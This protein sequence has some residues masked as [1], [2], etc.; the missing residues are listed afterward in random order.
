MRFVFI[1]IF[2]TGFVLAEDP[3]SP[4]AD[5]T[6]SF[7]GISVDASPETEPRSNWV[8]RGVVVRVSEEVWAL[9]DVDL[10]RLA[11]VWRGGFPEGITIAQFSYQNTKKKAAGGQKGVPRFE[12]SVVAA[13]GMHPGLWVGSPTH[14]FE[15]LRDRGSDEKE[16][17]RGPADFVKFGKWHGVH[18]TGGRPVIE[19]VLGETVVRESWRM[20][21]GKIARDFEFERAPK[22]LCVS[23]AVDKAA[24]QG[25]GASMY[26]GARRLWLAQGF[27]TARLRLGAE[28]N[29][30]LQLQSAAVS[31]TLTVYYGSSVATD[32]GE[33]LRGEIPAASTSK[34]AG[35]A[36]WPDVIT[37]GVRLSGEAAAYVTDRLELPVNNPWRRPVRPSGIAFYED[38]RA[39]VTTVDGDVWIVSGM[40]G[41]VKALKWKRFAAGLHEPYS[42]VV[43]EREVFV[44]TRSGLQRLLDRDNDDEADFYE[45]YCH[46]FWQSAETRDFP[47]DMV[48]RS[49]GGFYLVKGGQQN[50]H[51]SKHSGRVLSV[52][53]D[54]NKVEVFSSGHRNA[55]L[56]LDSESGDLFACDQQGH[57]VPTTPVQRLRRGGYYGFRP[58]SPGGNGLPGVE[59]PVTWIPHRAGQS[60]VDVVVTRK[61]RLGRLSDSVVCVDYFRPGLLKIYENGAAVR[62]GIPFEMPLLKGAVHPKDGLLYLVG[63]QIWGT[64]AAD[65]AGL[66]RVRRNS[67][68]P[69][70]IP[71]EIELG[72]E[73][74]LLQFEAPLERTEATD[75]GRYH[76]QSWNYVRS[77]SYGSGHYRSDGEPG[78][79]PLAIAGAHLSEDG[80]TVFLHVPNIPRSDQ[81]QLGFDVMNEETGERFASTVYLTPGDMTSIGLANRGFGD[82]DLEAETVTAAVARESRDGNKRK[83]IS[84]ER[85]EGISL[86][87]GCVA[88]HS[89][90]GTTEGKS[91][92]T[93][94]ELYGAQREFAKGATVLADDDYLRESILDPAA[95]M[96]KGYDPKDVGMP[97]YRGILSDDD[98]ESVLLFVKSLAGE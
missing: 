90:D 89:I 5:P 93:W 58:A 7:F 92:P 67:V 26:I 48:L 17:G 81:I 80:R 71:M 35:K 77:A 30:Y 78:Q 59:V 3:Y 2:L 11:A 19:Y 76:A 38:G 33:P 45:W 64:L 85:G 50:D 21:G 61:A 4:F 75:I 10:V 28:G 12:G 79:D 73:G 54:G 98:V 56:G 63:F 94:K 57:W 29:V 8:P 84:I 1:L 6:F 70:P 97:S 55:F 25:A 22:D 15:D 14:R 43:R 52:S 86:T 60:A 65:P 68:V 32:P 9:Y 74:V 37:T 49:D 18:D 51:L 20:E 96:V 39:V 36:H 40:G 72:T 69:D 47:H 46:D 34:P 13:T 82:V 62:L 83:P 23:L 91:G 24:A 53:P 31:R 44:F 87:Y 27:S 95:K 16:L 42:V 41:D 66:C 88:C